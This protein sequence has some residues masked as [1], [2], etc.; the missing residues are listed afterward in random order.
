MDTVFPLMGQ[1]LRRF[2]LLQ[3]PG[4]VSHVD[5]EFVLPYL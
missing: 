2:L 1:I 3:L 5:L 4:E